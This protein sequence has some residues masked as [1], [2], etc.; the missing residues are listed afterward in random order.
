MESPKR[1]YTNNQKKAGTLRK[2]FTST[3]SDIYISGTREKGGLEDPN[4]EEKIK[5][6]GKF[7]PGKIYTFQYDPLYKNVLDWYDLRPV[8]LVNNTFKAK[9]GN[10]IVTGINLNFLPERVRVATLQQF[11][12]LFENDINQ[13]EQ[14]AWSGKINLAV[15]KIVSFFRDWFNVLSAFNDNANVGY[16]FAYRNYIVDR[17]K[18]PRYMEYQHWEMIP[19]LNPEEIVGASIEQIYTTY[20]D[21]QARLLK[22]PKNEK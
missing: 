5:Q 10:F 15:N 19:F 9:T 11:Y 13:S 12:E 6:L 2:E 3:F 14:M 20:W 8:I 7:I 4:E 21:N 16:Q 1:A 22:G 18:D 17:I